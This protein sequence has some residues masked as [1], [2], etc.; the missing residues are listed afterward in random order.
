MT[1][2]TVGVNFQPHSEVE[3]PRGDVDRGSKRDVAGKIRV[4]SKETLEMERRPRS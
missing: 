2:L 4:I 1:L 3:R